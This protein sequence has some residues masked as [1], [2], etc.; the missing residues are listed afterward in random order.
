M[1]LVFSISLLHNYKPCT[2]FLRPICKNQT[3]CM[4]FV[5]RLPSTFVR[6]LF[7]MAFITLSEGVVSRG[8]MG[9]F[10]R[11]LLLNR[12]ILAF[13]IRR[14]FATDYKDYE[15][16][17]VEHNLVL[18]TKFTKREKVISFVITHITQWPAPSC[19]A[20]LHTLPSF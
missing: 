9:L 19:P 14:A 16:K 3:L 8:P 10:R 6:L 2:R 7:T 17:S 5:R 4:Q 20:T 18:W 15:K 13:Q 12:M 1:V 11:S